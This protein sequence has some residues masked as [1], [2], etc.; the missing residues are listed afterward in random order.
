MPVCDA[1]QFAPSTYYATRS[2]PPPER[3][4]RDG[5]LKGEIERI[6]RENYCV[7]GAR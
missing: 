7:Y 5:E 4:I 3:A 6:Y 1:L 2:G